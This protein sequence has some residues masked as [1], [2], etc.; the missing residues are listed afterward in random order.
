MEWWSQFIPV[1]I[2]LIGTIYKSPELAANPIWETIHGGII[3]YI[4][5]RLQ[6]SIK[7]TDWV[8]RCLHYHSVSFHLLADAGQQ[9]RECTLYVYNV[10]IILC[11]QVFATNN[12]YNGFMYTCIRTF[13]ASQIV[14]CTMQVSGSSLPGLH[15]SSFRKVFLTFIWPLPLRKKRDD[16][17]YSK[18]PVGH[19]HLSH[20]LCYGAKR[21]L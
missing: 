7:T 20:P 10:V 11:K 1:K 2:F 12:K 9:R 18:V 8:S 15:Q 19:T 21:S 5:H 14:L 6:K 13:A 4:W 17:W 3:S 16:V